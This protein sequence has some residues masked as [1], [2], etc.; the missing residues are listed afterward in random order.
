M[1]DIIDMSRQRGYFVDQSQSLNLFK[2]QL[3][4]I[5]INAFFM[6]GNLLKT[7]I[8]LEN[9]SCVDAIKFTLNN[10][11]KA[12]PI[13]ERRQLLCCCSGSG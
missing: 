1:K 6:L 8:L 13:D 5:N 3:C 2:M 9:K 4:K 10:D 12:E 7:G 11:K